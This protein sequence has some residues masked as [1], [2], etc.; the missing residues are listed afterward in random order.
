MGWDS[1]SYWKKWVVVIH[2]S[3]LCGRFNRDPMVLP[4]I[5]ERSIVPSG[6]HFFFLDFHSVSGMPK[7][8]LR[9]RESVKSASESRFRNA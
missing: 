4:P 1:H 5:R 6:Y 9:N 8:A 2:G 7:C 3:V